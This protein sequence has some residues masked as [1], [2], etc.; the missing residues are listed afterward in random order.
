M[1]LAMRHK[2]KMAGRQRAAN[3][4]ALPGKRPAAPQRSREVTEYENRRAELGEDLRSLK[5]IQSI[6]A[7]IARKA[8]LLPKYD[9]WCAGVLEAAAAA[10]AEDKRIET[11]DILV[12]TMVWA[13]DCADAE[14]AVPRAAVVI[15]H[16]MELPTRFER[17]AGCMIAEEFAETAMKALQLDETS[18]PPLAPFLTI[19]ELTEGEDMPDQVRAKLHRAIGEVILRAADVAP[20]GDQGPAGGKRAAITAA[21]G[22]FKRAL[23]LDSKAGVKKLIEARE[24]QLRD[25]EATANE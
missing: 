2:A 8:D 19:E 13:I 6:E 1:S 20:E 12:Q 18:V 14:R 11:D 7:K 10:Q 21:I 3:S 24:R 4:A 17:T 16:G 22:K 5:E 23:Q 25:L 15:G 9:D